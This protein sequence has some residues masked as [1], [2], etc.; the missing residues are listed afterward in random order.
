MHKDM[1]LMIMIVENGLK[2]DF[3]VY[4]SLKKYVDINIKGEKP[5]C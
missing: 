1:Y 2:G 4:I 5:D 3:S